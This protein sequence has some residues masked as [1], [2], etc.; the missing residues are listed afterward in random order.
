MPSSYHTHTPHYTTQSTALTGPSTVSLD[1]EADAKG[2]TNSSSSNKK[3]VDIALSPSRDK[4]GSSKT[5]VV[6]RSGGEA[7]SITD[8]GVRKV[9]CT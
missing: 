9:L 5:M 7:D 4:S 1:M 2:S 3:L 6:V 8:V